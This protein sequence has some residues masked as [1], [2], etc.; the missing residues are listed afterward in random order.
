MKGI[1]IQFKP[2][3]TQVI[4]SYKL[5]VVVAI[6]NQEDDLSFLFE[7]IKGA[8]KYPVLFSIVIDT[9]TNSD[10]VKA[11]ATTVLLERHN[12]IISVSSF[13]NPGGARNFGLERL[14]RSNNHFEWISFWDSD[15]IIQI[16][17]VMALCKDAKSEHEIIVGN[18][19]CRD[20][21]TGTISFRARRET[22][23]I[24]MIENPGLWRMLFRTSVIND[25]SFPDLRMGEDLTFLA[26][27]RIQKYNILFS[28]RLIYGYTRNRAMQLTN[29]V[30]NQDIRKSVLLISNELSLNEEKA[31]QFT[32]A[33]L[34][35][36]LGS[37]LKKT[38]FRSFLRILIEIYPSIGLKRMFA[39][40]IA[41][42]QVLRLQVL[43][44]TNRGK[45]KNREGIVILTGGLGNQLFQV[46]ALLTEFPSDTKTVVIDTG[47]PR[48]TNGLPDLL[49][50]D[51]GEMDLKT[52]ELGANKFSS[53]VF[54]FILRRGINPKRLE[55]VF[56]FNWVIGFLSKGFFSIK[57][58]SNVAISISNDVGFSNCSTRRQSTLL[59][60]YFQSW[61]WPSFDET[62]SRLSAIKPKVIGPELEQLIELAKIIKPI[63]LH[64]RLGDYLAESNFG[65]ISESYYNNAIKHFS[66]LSPEKEIW[67]FSDDIEM[68]KNKYHFQ[69]DKIT[70]WIDFIDDSDQSTFELMRYGYGYI[71]GNSTFSWWSAF[72]SH[73]NDVEVIAPKPWFLG[74]PEPKE[75][76]PLSWLRMDR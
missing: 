6:S 64:V 43:T 53:K 33:I 17:E 68:T 38:G 61:R 8:G 10:P 35:K 44:S 2:M 21:A 76:I 42:S 55:S 15:D 63:V 45:Q 41:A 31:D 40:V 9:G 67:V 51:L 57:L 39:L 54:G 20:Y 3:N 74:L 24:E 14:L 66:E 56:P 49:N 27:L 50:F 16:D 18:Y 32:V 75:L 69:S 1:A 26:R 47:R 7:M 52:M 5:G 11:R 29:N 48:T 12:T 72:L 71:L 70:R 36:Q 34:A 59:V 19:Y 65:L 28:D 23:T 37:Y 30:N 62:R 58:R 46:A 60:G 25:N 22:K 73:E 13:G 4:S